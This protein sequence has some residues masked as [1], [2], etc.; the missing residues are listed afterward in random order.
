MYVMSEPGG[1]WGWVAGRDVVW[2]IRV[3]QELTFFYANDLDYISTL[4]LYIVL[5]FQHVL[6]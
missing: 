3:E 4:H 5:I 1:S 6:F 2:V